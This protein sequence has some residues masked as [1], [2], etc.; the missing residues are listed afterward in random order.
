MPGWRGGGYP[1][2]CDVDW[3]VSGCGGDAGGGFEKCAR[4][5]VGVRCGAESA[6]DAV[7]QN[8]AGARVEGA[9]WFADVSLPGRDRVRDVDGKKGAGESDAGG[10]GKGVCAMKGRIKNEECR[11]GRMNADGTRNAEWKTSNIQQP[12]SN[13]EGEH[14]TSNLLCR[15]H[16]DF[17]KRSNNSAAFRLLL[18]HEMGRGSGRGGARG[19]GAKLGNM[20][21]TKHIER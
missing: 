15:K 21:S 3:V 5:F 9:D 1:G 11:R 18:R 10:V 13:E 12:T 6:G 8:G 14:R 4:R 2:E 20:F 7:D 17:E 16:R 19:S